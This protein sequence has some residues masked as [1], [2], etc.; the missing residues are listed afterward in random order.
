MSAP[1]APK[2]SAAGVSAA[3]AG[4]ALY[5]LS[6]YAFKGDVPAGVASMVYIAVP[7]IVAFVA[8]YLAPHQVRPGDTPPPVPVPPPAALSAIPI[9]PEQM[10]E[11]RGVL[12]HEQTAADERKAP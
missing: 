2:T 3:V 8:A 7:G 11:I 1:I 10:A 12:A 4:A 6:T 9:T 5:L